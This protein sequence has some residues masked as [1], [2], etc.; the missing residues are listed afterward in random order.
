MAGSSWTNQLVNLIILSA[1]QQG[2]SGFFVYSPAP[3]PGNLIGSWAAAAGTDP[4]GNP[5]PAGLSV[6]VGSLTGTDLFLYNGPPAAGNLLISL[7]AAGGADPHGNQYLQGIATY[8]TAFANSLIAGALIWYS[9]SLAGGWSFIGQLEVTGSQ[10]VADFGDVQFDGTVEVAGTLTAQG[11]AVVDGNLTVDGTSISAPNATAVDF[12]V[13]TIDV[14][15]GNVNLNMASPPNYPTSG[16]TLAQT[17]ACLDGLVTS[18][19]N[20]KLVA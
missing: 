4:F 11:A 13:A 19:I 6:E 15:N 17:Q 7:A 20:R 5:Y 8:S 10:L 9:G 12:D 16:K 3:G 2:F 1:A 14:A 18:M